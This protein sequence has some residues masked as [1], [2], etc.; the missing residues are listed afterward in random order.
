MSIDSGPNADNAPR[1]TTSLGPAL[2][3]ALV[4]PVTVYITSDL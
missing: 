4:S 2:T 3:S 1:I